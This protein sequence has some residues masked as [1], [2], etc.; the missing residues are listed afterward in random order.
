MREISRRCNGRGVKVS[1]V[2]ISQLCNGKLPPASDKI[3][4]VLEEVLGI[5]SDLKKDELKIA[6]YVERIPEDVLTAI[7]QQTT[8]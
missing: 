2:Y 7:M 5:V 8:S 4:K 3:N 6:A 1:S